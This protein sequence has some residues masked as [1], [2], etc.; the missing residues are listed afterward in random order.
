MAAKKT[1]RRRPDRVLTAKIARQWVDCPDDK[2]LDDYT[3]IDHAAAEIL[4]QSDDGRELNLSGLA[5]LTPAVARALAQYS[6]PLVL[7]GIRKVDTAIAR[8]LGSRRQDFTL[9]EGLEELTSRRLAKMLVV[10]GEENG[11]IFLNRLRKLSPE[12]ASVLAKASCWLNFGGHAQLSPEVNQILSRAKMV[13]FCGH[14]RLRLKHVLGLGCDGKSHDGVLVFVGTSQIDTDAAA[15]LAKY[16]GGAISFMSLEAISAEAAEALA[17][18]RGQLDIAS[19]LEHTPEAAVILAKRTGR[20]RTSYTHMTEASDGSLIVRLND[21][22]V[23]NLG[24]VRG[25]TPQLAATLAS[26]PILDLRNLKKLTPKAA[27]VLASNHHGT[28][29]LDGLDSLTDKVAA[30]LA[31][32]EG[33]LSL[34]KVRRLSPTAAR[35]LASIRGFLSL[36]GLKTLTPRLAAVLAEFRGSLMLD[37]VTKLTSGAARKL[38]KHTGILSMNGLAEISLETAKILAEKPNQKRMVRCG[39]SVAALQYLL[40]NNANQVTMMFRLNSDGAFE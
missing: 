1:T 39:G 31:K 21:D 26:A 38:Q 12:I 9:L 20:T 6:G 33:G 36:G 2:W 25:L 15:E 3:Y 35:H 23:F 28:L 16:P 32:H 34:R 40:Q 22:S 10:C 19:V 13:R 29:L 37:G 18:Y 30:A 17:P 11:D 8:I 5:T 4:G 7:N 27:L 24:E 14:K